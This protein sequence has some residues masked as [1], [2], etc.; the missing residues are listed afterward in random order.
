MLLSDEQLVRLAKAAANKGNLAQC[1]EFLKRVSEKNWP[2]QYFADI[3]Y[4]VAKASPL[5]DGGLMRDNY[6]QTPRTVILMK[7]SARFARSGIS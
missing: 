6:L 7:R 3:T 2:R 1:R 5:Q 4:Q